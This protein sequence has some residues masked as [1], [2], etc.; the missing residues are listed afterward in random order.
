MYEY[1]L[2]MFSRP[3][4]TWKPVSRGCLVKVKVIAE[5]TWYKSQPPAESTVE[6]IIVH[7]YGFLQ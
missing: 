5:V 1:V 3:K 7:D 2:F 6:R 4:P